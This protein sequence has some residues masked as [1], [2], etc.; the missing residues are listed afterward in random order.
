MANQTGWN[1]RHVCN[2]VL[3]RFISSTL[4]RGQFA[5]NAAANSSEKFELALRVQNLS[6]LLYLGQDLTVYSTQK[7]A[8]VSLRAAKFE[9]RSFWR[10]EHLLKKFHRNCREMMALLKFLFLSLS[11]VYS[12][13]RYL[14]HIV[15]SLLLSCENAISGR[16]LPEPCST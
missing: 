13:I 15:Y 5:K 8:T 7:P 9:P 14:D 6:L 1:N 11:K 2:H 16:R 12:W 10:Y 3:W 4:C